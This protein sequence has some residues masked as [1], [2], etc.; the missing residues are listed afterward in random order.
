MARETITGQH[1]EV[2][3]NRGLFLISYKS[4]DDEGSPPLVKIFP[5]PGHEGQIQIITHPD[6]DPN[7][8]W[9]P[10]TSL[11]VRA[12]TAAKLHVEVIAGRPNG[13]RNA[14]VRIEP[15]NQGQSSEPAYLD[16][17]LLDLD[18]VRIL[19]HVAGIGD[20]VVGPDQWIA[21]PAA[22]SRIEG[23]AIEWPP[24]AGLQLRYAVKSGSSPT[25]K[26]VEAGEFAGTRGRAMP[27]TGL[28]LELSGP[29]SDAY[30]VAADAIFLSSPTMRVIGKRVVLSGPTG[31][32]PLVG[33]RIRLESAEQ[34]PAAM[35]PA[36]PKPAAQVTVSTVKIDDKPPS[37]GRVRVFRSRA[38]QVSE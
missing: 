34:E 37:S 29:W 30:Q 10:N 12:S 4:A 20:V 23:V 22:P 7:T 2:D 31:R 27:L 8:L 26:L 33:L 5:A 28:I 35:L 38:K 16:S 15:I 11:V 21:G 13:S 3:L 18:Q 32:E 24:Q 9:Q 36:R 17:D 6:A 1:K 19:G 25:G 14:A